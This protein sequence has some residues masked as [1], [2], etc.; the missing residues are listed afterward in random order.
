MC[1]CQ[2]VHLFTKELILGASLASGNSAQFGAVLVCGSIMKIT[3]K[4]G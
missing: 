2:T 1:W 3:K 4:N